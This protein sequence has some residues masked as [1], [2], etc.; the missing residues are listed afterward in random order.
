M[1]ILSTFKR[2]DAAHIFLYTTIAKKNP[3]VSLIINI[4][5]HAKESVT[6]F[7]PPFRKSKLQGENF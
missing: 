5:E 1:P 4:E 2:N 7:P 3:G 6:H